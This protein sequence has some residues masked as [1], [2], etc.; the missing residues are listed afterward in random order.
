MCVLM[1]R[2]ICTRICI[3]L[4]HFAVHQKLTQHC[5]LTLLQFFLMP[6]TE[7]LYFEDIR[8]FLSSFHKHPL[9]PCASPERSC[10]ESL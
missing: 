1:Y 4:N 2:H 5:K 7:I 9:R 8:K 6:I 10:D 3:K